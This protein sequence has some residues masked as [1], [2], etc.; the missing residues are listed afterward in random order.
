M[1]RSGSPRVLHLTR[2]YPP[3]VMG[4][5]SRAV[6]GLVEGQRAGGATAYVVSV[7][8]G[9]AEE[10]FAAD[11]LRVGRAGPQVLPPTWTPE[12]LHLHDG[13]LW[14]L[15]RGS[16]E[17]L[18]VV[19]TVHVDH[20]EMARLRDAT[21]PDPSTIGHD[22]ALA[23]ANAVIAPT[24]EAAR[25][26]GDLGSVDGRLHVIGHG[27]AAPPAVTRT[28]SA[29]FDVLYVG[30]FDE[31][32]GTADLFAATPQ[33]LSTHPR[34]RLVIAGGLPA[35]KKAE[36][37][38]LRRWAERWPADIQRRVDFRGWL[39]NGALARAYSGACVL[40]I[41]SRYETFCLTALEG[42]AHGI[43][44]VAARAGGLAEILDGYPLARFFP[45][46][47]TRALAARV[48]ER[49]A[50]PS[51]TD[52]P[53]AATVLERFQWPR[54]IAATADVYRSCLS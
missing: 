24:A 52:D 30:R 20:R 44:I 14:P 2:D 9:R 37:R 32:K 6:H 17:Q 36:R 5:I 1:V 13:G 54:C 39:A 7:E 11:T 8:R 38:W 41:P 23:G 4:G 43:P 12:V 25:V 29:R 31:R 40:V 46:G 49:L 35:N 22:L 10:D 48:E 42:M 53:A 45:A 50:C 3:P 26:L 51:G 28:S 27:I 16:L 21:S 15:V 33:F 34:A 18:P 47:D 19:Y